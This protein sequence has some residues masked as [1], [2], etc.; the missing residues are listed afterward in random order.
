MLE[1]VWKN[2]TSL[3]GKVHPWDFLFSSCRQILTKLCY[4]FTFSNQE[5]LRENRC[6]QHW[7]FYFQV[8][9]DGSILCDCS[10]GRM[11]WW[12]E[13]MSSTMKEAG[14]K[15]QRSSTVIAISKKC[16]KHLG[17]PSRSASCSCSGNLEISCS[18]F[19]K[20]TVLKQS[21]KSVLQVLAKQHAFVTW[22]TISVTAFS[23]IPISSSLIGILSW[24]F[25]IFWQA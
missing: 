8:D 22:G 24:E 11:V 1:A 4:N 6:V 25:L 13:G 7:V 2:Y 21:Q 23:Q 15:A 14:P 20:C 3:Q 10:R 12:I 17:I 18:A 5:L 19:C 16:N 9:Q